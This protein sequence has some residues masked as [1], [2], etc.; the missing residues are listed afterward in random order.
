[1]S[2]SRAITSWVNTVALSVAVAVGV[3]A[4]GQH[5]HPL[6]TSAAVSTSARTVTTPA[7]TPASHTASAPTSVTYHGDDG[8]G[9]GDF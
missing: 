1:M 3:I 4:V 2:R 7:A 9:G 5:L 6:P 8:G